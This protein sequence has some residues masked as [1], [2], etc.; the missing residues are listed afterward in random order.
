MNLADFREL[1]YVLVGSVGQGSTSLIFTALSYT[2]ETIFCASIANKVLSVLPLSLLAIQ[3]N[4]FAPGGQQKRDQLIWRRNAPLT[5]A[6]KLF[7]VLTQILSTLLSRSVSLQ[8]LYCA[9]IG[10]YY[11]ASISHNKT[12]YQKVTWDSFCN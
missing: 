5:V 3:N 9:S 4:F 2:R 10:Q 8:I 11:S 1:T 6:Y 7:Y 12:P